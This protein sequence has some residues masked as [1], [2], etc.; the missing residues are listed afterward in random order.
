M[1]LTGDTVAVRVTNLTS[2]G[3]QDQ[4]TGQIVCILQ[5]VKKAKVVWG[6]MLPDRPRWMHPQ[7]VLFV[8]QDLDDHLPM[9]VPLPQLPEHWV[10]KPS[11]DKYKEIFVIEVR[12]F[13]HGFMY[14]YVSNQNAHGCCGG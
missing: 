8:P 2:L 13:V 7:H 4:P 14:Q 1:T 10:S 9:L 5:R 12:R 6:L 11:P 3:P